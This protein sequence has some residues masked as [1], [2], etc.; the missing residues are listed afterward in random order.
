MKLVELEP[1]FIRYELVVETWRRIIVDQET[2]RERGCPSE[3]V[4]EP[5]EHLIIVPTLAEAQGIFFLCPKCFQG[6]NCHISFADR[7]VPDNL[8]T[9]NNDGNSV[10]WTES[11]TGLADLTTKPSIQLQGGCN[12]HGFITNGDVHE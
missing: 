12:W 8:G 1:E 11:G 4:T 10:R 2:W 6:H 3:D 7:G 9:H 5:R